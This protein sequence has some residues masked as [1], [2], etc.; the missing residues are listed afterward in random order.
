[1]ERL[2]G[3]AISAASFGS[4]IF[5]MV[6]IAAIALAILGVFGFSYA[7]CQSQIAAGYAKAE[8]DRLEDLAE[9]NA[10]TALKLRKDTASARAAEKRYRSERDRALEAAR[11]VIAARKAAKPEEEPPICPVGCVISR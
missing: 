11:V 2:I 5:S 9:Q 1:M 10:E 7:G 3:T 8:A 4:G 6:K